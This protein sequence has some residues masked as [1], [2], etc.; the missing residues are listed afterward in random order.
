MENALGRAITNR[1]ELE[2]RLAQLVAA[3]KRTDDVARVGLSHAN[4]LCEL[5]EEAELFAANRNVSLDVGIQMRPDL[6]LFTQSAHYILVELKTRA[7][8]ERQGVQELLAYSAAMKLRY[9]YVN[10][11]LYIVV[12]GAWEPLLARSVQALI[13]AGKRVLP[14]QWTFHDL[15]GPMPPQLAGELRAVPLKQFTLKIRLDLFEL[16]F[17]QTYTPMQALST[18]TVGVSRHTQLAPGVGNYF[19]RL[20]YRA[21]TDCA[22]M[23]QTGFALVWA[24]PDEGRS[25]E[26]IHVTLATVNQ[27]WVESARLPTDLSPDTAP[28]RG[29][30]SLAH[31][32][33]SAKRKRLLKGV[34]PDDFFAQADASQ[35]AS[36]FF[37]QSSLSEE[38]LE[39]HR[40]ASAEARLRTSMLQVGD[41]DPGGRQLTLREFVRWLERAPEPVTVRACYSFGEFDDFLRAENFSLRPDITELLSMFH[42]FEIYKKLRH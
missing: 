30:A 28:L 18:S 1:D 25:T 39:R 35:A 23:H 27:H 12:A 3:N 6:I 8:A 42:N 11:F 31:R 16:N 15:A 14:L 41:F 33:A 37:P 24:Y 4:D 9:P 36:A 5:M 34:D 7:G 17:V 10:D 26:I 13:M 20:A 38:V 21:A 29:V 22:R 32:V 19:R 40:D 2:T